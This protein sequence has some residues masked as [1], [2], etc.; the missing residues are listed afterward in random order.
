MDFRTQFL[1]QMQYLNKTH[2]GLIRENQKENA[3]Y[4]YHRTI[5]MLYL[6]IFGLERYGILLFT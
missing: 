6:L 2:F 4:I 1:N 5:L 3:T